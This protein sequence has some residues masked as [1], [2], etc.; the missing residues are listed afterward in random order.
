MVPPH[1][2]SR[3][4]L[5]GSQGSANIGVEGSPA[6]AG[7]DRSCDRSRPAANGISVPPHTRAIDPKDAGERCEAIR[8]VP[9]A[10]RGVHR[11]AFHDAVSP[12]CGCGIAHAGIDLAGRLG[13]CA[14]VVGFPFAHAGID[15]CGARWQGRP[16]LEG[17]FADFTN[18]SWSFWS[19]PPPPDNQGSPA[20]AGIGRL[21]VS[22]R[23]ERRVRRGLAVPAV[24]WWMRARFMGCPRLVMCQAFIFL[25]IDRPGGLV[26]NASIPS[27]PMQ[28]P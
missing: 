27:N 8:K 4:R 10:L 28:S 26:D 15:L 17:S 13:S 22:V 23:P 25:T 24:R 1:T 2:R 7:I 19:G 3:P 16:G 11:F 6:H 12:G 18:M 20:H 21:R 14:S 5:A 9:R